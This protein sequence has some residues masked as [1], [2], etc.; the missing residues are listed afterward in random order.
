MYGYVRP[1]KGELKVS[2]FERF[3]GVYCGLCHELARRYGFIARFLVNYDF[4]FL[5]MLLAQPGPAATCP[6]RCAAHPI[7]RTVCLE[8]CES[9]SMAADMTVILGWWKLADGGADRAFLASW[10]CKAACM[11][12]KRAYKKAAVRQP[13]FAGTVEKEL[14]ALQALEKAKCPSMDEAADKFACILRA[15]GAAVQ[16]EAKGRVLSELLYHLGRIIYILDAADDLAEDI[17]TD[18]Y[19]P[20]RYRFKPVDG[21]LSAEDE[22]VIRTSLQHSHNALA[23]AYALLDGNIYAGI[24]SNTIYLGLPAAAQAVFSGTWKASAGIQRERS[25]I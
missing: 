19:N 15:V 24:L 5:A 7:K 10:G 14:R 3:R 18:S 22:Q 1:I 23:G 25:L 16:D 20:L 8:S 11:A 17:K 2:E 12:L 13:D 21:K 6:R 4:T 9:L